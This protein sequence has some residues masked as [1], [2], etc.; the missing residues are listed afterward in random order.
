M[1]TL[2]RID[3]L[4][5]L[6]KCMATT[7]QVSVG[8]AEQLISA[9][10]GSNPALVAS[11]SPLNPARTRRRDLAALVRSESAPSDLSEKADSVRRVAC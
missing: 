7:P 10:A 5:T 3:V 8:G 2:G 1:Y 9:I 11:L 6:S 4:P